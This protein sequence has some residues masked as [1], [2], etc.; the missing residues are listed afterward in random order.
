MQ[1]EYP[2]FHLLISIPKSSTKFFVPLEIRF[3]TDWPENCAYKY[4]SLTAFRRNSLL[5]TL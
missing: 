3:K 1:C 5:P 2:I 4:S